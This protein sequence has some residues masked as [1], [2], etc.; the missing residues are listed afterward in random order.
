MD[1]ESLHLGRGEHVPGVQ[2][3]TALHVH[4]VYSDRGATDRRHDHC[5]VVRDTHV[6]T[7][8]D[9]LSGGQVRVFSQSHVVGQRTYQAVSRQTLPLLLASA[10]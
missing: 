10:E 2:P 8:Y 9:G 6:G 5:R 3:L 7:V 1:T 4:D